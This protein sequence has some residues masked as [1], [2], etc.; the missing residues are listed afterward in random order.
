MLTADADM[1]LVHLAQRLA[2]QT[3]AGRI[4]WSKYASGR[5]YLYAGVS[6]SVTL[7]RDP[8]S[9]RR[10]VMRVRDQHGV[11]VDELAAT[12]PRSGLVGAPADAALANLY[13]AVTASSQTVVDSLLAE[14]G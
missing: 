9:N 11:A 7:E 14:I 10:L 13:D 8:E 12:P 4:S 2:E 3:R 5:R 1:R 6:G